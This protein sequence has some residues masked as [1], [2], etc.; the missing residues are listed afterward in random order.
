MSI[1]TAFIIRVFFTT[2]S[3]KVVSLAYVTLIAR[4]L[5]NFVVDIVT[6]SLGDVN[7]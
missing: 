7:S 3:V 5:R 2:Y 4:S 1:S 6:V